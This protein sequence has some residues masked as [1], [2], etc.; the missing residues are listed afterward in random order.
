MSA[1]QF[2]FKRHMSVL[3]HFLPQYQHILHLDADSLFL[4]LSQPLARFLHRH[5]VSLHLNPNG[6]VTAAAYLL[7][8]VPSAYC[9]MRYWLGMRPHNFF[10][11]VNYDNG[12]LVSAMGSLIAPIEFP[13]CVQSRLSSYEITPADRGRYNIIYHETIVKC[14]QKLQ[15]TLL[16]RLRYHAP[17]VRIFHHHEGFWRMKSRTGRFGAW[18]DK[19]FGTCY[20]SDIIGH[21]WQAMPRELWGNSTCDIPRFRSGGGS[22]TVCQ[23]HS[24]EEE[25]KMQQDYCAWRSPLCRDMSCV[26]PPSTCYQL[27]HN[28]EHQ[29]MKE[30]NI[31]FDVSNEMWWKQQICSACP[32]GIAKMSYV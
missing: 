15:P 24:F 18:W 19:L 20:S 32:S 30:L 25:K 16:R 12:D 9:F 11:V 31:E 10:D 3:Q 4:N 29:R 8:N 14:F 27:Y 6:E 17:F 2:F 7:R 26:R 1:G 28:N 23:W 22:N 5:A 21:G 13:Y